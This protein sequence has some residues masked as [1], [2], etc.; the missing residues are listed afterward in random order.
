MIDST[1]RDTLSLEEPEVGVVFRLFA[2]CSNVP[3]VFLCPYINHPGETFSKW[4]SYIFHSGI[5][6]VITL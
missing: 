5:T 1:F 6:V 3:S 4:A 2:G